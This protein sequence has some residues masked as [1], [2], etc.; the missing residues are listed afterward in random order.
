MRSPMLGLRTL[1]LVLITIVIITFDHRTVYFVKLRAILS[2]VVAPLQYI[3]DWPIDFVDWLD[4]SFTTHQI[5]VAENASL[6]VQQLLLKAQLQKLLA[7]EKENNQLRA[8]LTSSPHVSNNRILVAQVLA[9]SA[10]PFLHQIVLD[11][12]SKNGV[13]LGQPVLD[14]LGVM[15]QVV[16]VSYSTSRVM[17]LSDSRSAIPIEVSRNGI[18]GIVTGGGVSGRLALAHIPVTTDIQVGDKLVSSGLGLRYPIGYPVGTV[19]K[20]TDNVAQSFMDIEVQ[21]SALFDRSRLVLLIWPAQQHL[22]PAVRKQLVQLNKDN[23]KLKVAR[24]GL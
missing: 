1:L 6:R 19:V 14:A 2:T 22:T 7:L 11:R 8:L 18:R 21:P 9:V 3:V 23:A 13:Y 5:L 20:I 16:Q 15:G 24:R 4:S 10:A 17:L 12:G